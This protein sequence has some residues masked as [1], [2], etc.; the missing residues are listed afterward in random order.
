MNSPR[1]RSI[2]I[3]TFNLEKSTEIMELLRD[4]EVTVMPLNEPSVS[5]LST[6]KRATTNPLW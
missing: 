6:P 5:F 2:V 1:S 3:G 4:L